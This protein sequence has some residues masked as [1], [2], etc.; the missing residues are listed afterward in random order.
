MIVFLTNHRAHRLHP[1]LSCYWECMT[2]LR[3]CLIVYPELEVLIANN[4]ENAKHNKPGPISVMKTIFAELDCELTTNWTVIC[5]GMSFHFINISQQQWG[6]NVRKIFK[7]F[8]I[9]NVKP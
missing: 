1:K 7:R 9:R 3:R 5:D 2:N 4:W 8:L 6:H